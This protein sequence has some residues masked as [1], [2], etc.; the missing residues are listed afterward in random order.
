MTAIHHRSGALVGAA[1]AGGPERAQASL[2]G[3]RRR[4]RGEWRGP[5]GCVAQRRAAKINNWRLSTSGRGGGQE[6]R[7]KWAAG[8]A[9]RG[10]GARAGPRRDVDWFELSI[11]P[12]V[13]C[14]KFS[15]LAPCAA[16]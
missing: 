2:R 10:A 5:P 6:T 15:N 7:Q 8:G 12:T 14:L 11:L 16:R 13:K 9:G 3:G 4:Q 1:P